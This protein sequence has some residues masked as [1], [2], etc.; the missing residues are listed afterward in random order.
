LG[1][2]LGVV[3][4]LIAG[5]STE[6]RLAEQP[7]QLVAHVLTAAAI[8][9]LRD[10]DLG[11]PQDVIQLTVGEQAT[12]GGDPGTV[13][14]ELDP[15]VKSGPQRQLFGFTRRA[16]HDHSPSVVPTC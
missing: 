11:E 16:P 1:K 2:P 7:T 4:I 3:D 8:E 14:F 10:R 5:E 13:E 12:V 9:E 15:A 6:H